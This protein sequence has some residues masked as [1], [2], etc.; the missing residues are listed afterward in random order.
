[1]VAH[2][3]QLDLLGYWVMTVEEGFVHSILMHTHIYP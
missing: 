3:G 1:M 2:S